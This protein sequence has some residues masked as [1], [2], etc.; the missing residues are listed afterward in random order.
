MS[1]R[2]V[3]YTSQ[4]DKL[5]CQ[6]WMEISQD[7]IC[8][9]EQK[10]AYWWKIGKYFYEQR[11]LKSSNLYSDQ[12]DISLENRWSSI[13]AECNKF[14][15]AYEQAMVMKVSGCLLKPSE[16][17]SKPVMLGWRPSK[18]RSNP[19]M[20][21]EASVPP[22]QSCN[23]LLFECNLCQICPFFGRLTDV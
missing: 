19:K 13:N 2:T 23:L 7:P 5:L 16:R 15:G 14:Q 18:R 8:G 17:R 1:Q 22:G 9:A 3:N 6:V 10:G 11:N 4:E 12:N 21:V 20:L